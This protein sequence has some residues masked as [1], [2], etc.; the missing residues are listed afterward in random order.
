MLD[1]NAFANSSD[2]MT[3]SKEDGTGTAKRGH[4]YKSTQGK[5]V[6]S[7]N[8]NKSLRAWNFT[9]KGTPDCSKYSTLYI[10]G[11]CLPG[12]DS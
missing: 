7:K 4:L 6:S 9:A 8:H 3:L 10:Q 5:D 2:C 1:I 12:P 11:K